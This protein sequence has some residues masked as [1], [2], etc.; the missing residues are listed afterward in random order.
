MVI[1][2]NGQEKRLER[3]TTVRELLQLLDLEE[4]RVAVE[5]NLEIVD[6]QQFSNLT[7][8]ESDKVEVISFVGGGV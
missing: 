2:L 8:K 1:I 7:L 5:V 6:R 4:G 3:P